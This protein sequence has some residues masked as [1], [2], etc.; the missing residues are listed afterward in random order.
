MGGRGSSRTKASV[1]KDRVAA[2]R[3]L[4]TYGWSVPQ[5][6]D[7]LRISA[8]AV[9]AAL[10]QA[11]RERV[12]R[13]QKP[14]TVPKPR[15]VSKPAP[16]KA[17]PAPSDA[18]PTTLAGVDPSRFSPRQ[19]EVVRLHLAGLND[20][21]VG[22]RL[23]LKVSAVAV[24]LSQA[25][26]RVGIPPKQAGFRRKV[27]SAPAPAQSPPPLPRPTPPPP[28]V[29]VRAARA[30]APVLTAPPPPPPP[31][32]PPR[33]PQR[34]RHRHRHHIAEMSV[35]VHRPQRMMMIIIIIH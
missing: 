23:G 31:P 1:F 2:V 26:R 22:E 18:A 35:K 14:K 16:I 28:P 34:R 17:P 6:A 12:K 29:E 24:F 10:E 25:R 4:Y 15:A 30:E 8:R 33:P 3:K 13:K 9:S 32:P 20:R 11:L 5:M 21:K 19:R 27:K 7:I